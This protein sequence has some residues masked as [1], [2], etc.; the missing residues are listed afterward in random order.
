MGRENKNIIVAN[1]SLETLKM[2]TRML[3][4][5]FIWYE[6]VLWPRELKMP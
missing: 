1:R 2:K 3:Y 4:A 6:F 5:I